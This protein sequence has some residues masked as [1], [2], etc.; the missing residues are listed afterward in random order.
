[1]ANMFGAVS[2]STSRSKRT[3]SSQADE[4][5][6]SR[7]SRG[8]RLSSTNTASTSAP[9]PSTSAAAMAAELDLDGATVEGYTED[10]RARKGGAGCAGQGESWKDRIKKAKLAEQVAADRR[11]QRISQAQ[12]KLDAF[13]DESGGDAFDGDAPDAR[14][15][16]GSMYDP[17]R[18]TASMVKKASAAGRH[19]M[20]PPRPKMSFTL[21]KK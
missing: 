14:G 6:T 2:A 12:A 10:V 17:A 3:H 13:D 16:G 20:E 8:S 21:G 18:H 9:A 7:S 1:M 5:D 4:R 19:A 11:M 15:S